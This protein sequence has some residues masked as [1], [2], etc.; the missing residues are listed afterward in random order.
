M[1]SSAA[2]ALVAILVSP[3]NIL[4]T[5]VATRRSKGLTLMR[6]VQEGVT[7]I[8]KHADATRA[9]LNISFVAEQANLVLHDNGRGIGTGRLRELAHHGHSSLQEIRAQLA[10][11][12]GELEIESV[13][14]QGT[15]LWVCIP[16][17]CSIGGSIE[18]GE[19][20]LSDI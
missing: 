1:L 4:I 17:S 8:Y 10:L 2:L 13:G 3:T 11:V 20:K 19:A 12:N 16:Y 9:S 18:P 5:E 14:G 7:N 6:V 15:T